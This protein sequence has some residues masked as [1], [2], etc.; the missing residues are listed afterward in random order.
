MRQG[1]LDYVDHRNVKK[2]VDFVNWSKICP[3]EGSR[4]WVLL[5]T[6]DCTHCGFILSGFQRIPIDLDIRKD[7][8]TTL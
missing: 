1:Q 6:V 3:Q 5:L 8:R 7:T 2:E 4:K